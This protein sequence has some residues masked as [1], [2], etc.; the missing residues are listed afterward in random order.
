MCVCVCAY[1]V[2]YTVVGLAYMIVQ[3]TGITIYVHTIVTFL[4]HYK[5]RELAYTCACIYSQYHLY[6]IMS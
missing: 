1:T 3:C 5:Q 2:E 4:I 6:N